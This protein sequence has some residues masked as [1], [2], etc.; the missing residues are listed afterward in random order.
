MA[1]EKAQVLNDTVHRIVERIVAVAH[2]NR[3][4]LFGSAARGQTGADSDYDMLVIV[5]GTADVGEL[6]GQVYCNLDGILAP[7]DVLVV[8]E[9]EVAKYGTRVGSIIGP[10]LRDGITVYER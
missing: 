1:D 3:I 2:P 4:L 10:A 5:G 6:E 7:V 9:D 8:T